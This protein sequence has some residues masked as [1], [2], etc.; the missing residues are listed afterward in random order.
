MLSSWNILWTWKGCDFCWRRCPQGD[1]TGSLWM[2]WISPVGCWTAVGIHYAF[3]LLFAGRQLLPFGLRLWVSRLIISF[4][5]CMLLALLL[6]CVSEE[7]PSVFLGFP[8]TTWSPLRTHE[9]PTK[10]ILLYNLTLRQ[11]L[12]EGLASETQAGVTSCMACGVV[13]NMGPLTSTH[14]PRLG[15]LRA[16]QTVAQKIFRTFLCFTLYPIFRFKSKHR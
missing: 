4:L 6:G 2:H 1:Q 16:N 13:N 14:Q 9:D 7:P 3:S 8:S 15:L 12:L 5:H 10:N 11:C